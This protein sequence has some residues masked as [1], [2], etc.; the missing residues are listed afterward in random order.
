MDKIRETMNREE[1][2]KL[3]DYFRAQ[4]IGKLHRV[5]KRYQ[6]AITLNAVFFLQASSDCDYVLAERLG[7][8]LMDLLGVDRAAYMADVLSAVQIMTSKDFMKGI[9]KTFGH[10]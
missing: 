3:N 5:D 8:I 1:S 6:S 4:L 2:E 10:F 7:D 9:Q